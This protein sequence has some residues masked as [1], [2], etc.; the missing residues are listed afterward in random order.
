M[1]ASWRSWVRRAPAASAPA[2]SWANRSTASQSVK[3]W[4]RDVSVGW[5]PLRI[6]SRISTRVV[7]SYSRYWSAPAN[8]VARPGVQPV[9]STNSSR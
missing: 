7:K 2:H 4:S 6:I 5:P 8:V 1:A 9:A 3:S